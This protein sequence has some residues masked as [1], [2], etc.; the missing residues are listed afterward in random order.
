MYF[1]YWLLELLVADC[2]T[3]FPM[4][5]KRIGRCNCIYWCAFSPRD[6]RK[7]PQCEKQLWKL[8]KK[9]R[10]SVPHECEGVPMGCQKCNFWY[11][12]KRFKQIPKQDL[13]LGGEP[14]EGD[15]VCLFQTL[16]MNANLIS[17]LLVMD[18][19]VDSIMNNHL[20]DPI[21]T[22]ILRKRDR[23][24]TYKDV[25]MHQEGCGP[26]EHKRMR[27]CEM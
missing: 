10:L 18:V 23:F 12:R 3:Y 2:I 20:Y 6:H 15:Q 17:R 26:F 7:W 14:T 8:E 25:K 22:T 1:R 24:L 9:I 19:S 21:L 11:T 16:Q 27:W 4:S 13:S 5:I